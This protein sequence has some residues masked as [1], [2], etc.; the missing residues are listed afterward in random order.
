MPDLAKFAAQVEDCDWGDAGCRC[1]RGGSSV[2][3]ARGFG[4]FAEAANLTN[5]EPN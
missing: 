5:S 3:A 1:D 4:G 2:L